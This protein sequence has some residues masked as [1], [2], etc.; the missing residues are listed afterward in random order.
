MRKILWLALIGGLAAVLFICWACTGNGVDHETD[1]S[2][3]IDDDGDMF[4]DCED[5]DCAGFAGCAPDGDGDVDGDVDGDADTDTDTDGDTD[6]DEQPPEDGDRPQDADEDTLVGVPCDSP[7]VETELFDTCIMGDCYESGVTRDC[8]VSTSIACSSV[9]TI[10]DLYTDL[11]VEYRGF[12]D[13]DHECRV[14][15]FESFGEQTFVYFAQ[16]RGLACAFGF[17]RVHVQGTISEIT[18]GFEYDLCEDPALP[19]LRVNVTV[20]GDDSVNYTNHACSTPGRFQLN[21]IG[22]A[23]GERYELSF[24][25]RLSELDGDDPTGSYV[26]VD[27]TSDGL[28]NVESGG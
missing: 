9:L 5:P 15:V 14:R 18:P 24:S 21:E 10:G 19:N 1:C 7:C 6:A 22:E 12:F 8:C 26:E 4:A 13:N 11:T 2:N 25:G 20:G 23:S 27:V 28:I 3:R 16:T 17:V